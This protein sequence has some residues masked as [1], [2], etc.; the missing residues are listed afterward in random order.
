MGPA[1]PS[2]PAPPAL[3][4]PPAPPGPN[5]TPGGVLAGDSGRLAS[6]LA[7]SHWGVSTGAPTAA[8]YKHFSVRPSHQDHMHVARRVIG[9][10][11]LKKQGTKHV[12]MR[13]S[14]GCCSSRYILQFDSRNE[15]R[16]MLLATS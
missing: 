7:C 8:A 10:V 1:P 3:P 4:T 9:A 6:R 2:P 15:V 11:W 5:S 16:W 13:G 12:V 14:G